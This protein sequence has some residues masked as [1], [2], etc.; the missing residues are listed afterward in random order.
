MDKTSPRIITR[1]M[2][3]EGLGT[4]LL[5][6]TIAVA[7]TGLSRGYPGYQA[8][9]VPF[10]AGLT[11]FVLAYLFGP[12]SGAHCNPAV[13]VALFVFRQISSFQLGMYLVAQF[14]GGVAGGLLARLMLDIE[15]SAPLL[16]TVSSISGEFVGAMIL[17][18][19]VTM[20]V[21]K[22]VPESA[23]PAVIGGCL[24]IG[25]SIS[26]V[27]GGGLLNPAIALGLGVFKLTYLAV[28]FLGGLT[29]AALAI[30]FHES[31]DQPATAA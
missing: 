15:P 30:I 6:A 2:L 11:L 22:R 21:L 4:A 27:T 3:A 20:V 25:V 19:G 26:A 17:V 28:P 18:L 23:G 16:S 10:V 14:L 29:G 24:F 13:S 5:T 9:F 31:S 8:A 7:A 1:W 12:I